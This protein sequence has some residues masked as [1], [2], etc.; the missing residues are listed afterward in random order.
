MI[1]PC[2]WFP[3]TS[4]LLQ[5]TSSSVSR[6]SA[7]VSPPT[8][9]GP[10][11]SLTCPVQS[12]RRSPEVARP[13]CRRGSHWKLQSRA[14]HP[15][16]HTPLVL[17]PA[18]RSK[19]PLLSFEVPQNPSLPRPHRLP[20]PPGRPRD[21]CVPAALAFRWCRWNTGH[22]PDTHPTHTPP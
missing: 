9:L 22:V 6:S 14:C 1:V 21:A 16:A 4:N 8:K 15:P 2:L 20:L 5:N 13:N 3:E 11:L 10:P 19:V 12:A 7:R 18:S 17:P